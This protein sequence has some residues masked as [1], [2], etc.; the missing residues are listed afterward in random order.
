MTIPKMIPFDESHINAL[1]LDERAGGH[2]QHSGYAFTL[3]VDNV[4]MA[5]LGYENLL[6]DSVTVWAAFSQKAKEHPGVAWSVRVLCDSMASRWNI[7][8][9]VREDWEEALRLAKWLKFERI[10]TYLVTN[11]VR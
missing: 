11:G 5:C 2:I 8:I 4:P 3:V 7:F 9:Y 6:N 1:I 10:D